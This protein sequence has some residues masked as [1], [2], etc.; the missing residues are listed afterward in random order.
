MNQ[1]LKELYPHEF[2][3]LLEAV[4]RDMR[5]QLALSHTASQWAVWHKL[6]ARSDQRLLEVLNPKSGRN[7]NSEASV[8]EDGAIPLKFLISPNPYPMHEAKGPS[9]EE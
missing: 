1:M 3:A 5:R 9:N 4:R 6:N 2:R 7:G 8:T